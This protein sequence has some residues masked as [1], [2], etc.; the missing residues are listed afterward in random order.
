MEVTVNLP[1]FQFQLRREN[2]GPDVDPLASGAEVQLLRRNMQNMIQSELKNLDVKLI[3][4]PV[5]LNAV[6]SIEGYSVA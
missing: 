3:M 2:T 6:V 5:N 4:Y 1:F